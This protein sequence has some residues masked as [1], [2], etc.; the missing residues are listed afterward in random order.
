MWL[1]SWIRDLNTNQLTGTIPS[2]LGMLQLQVLYESILLICQHEL[3][4]DC[5]R[6]HSNLQNNQLLS[7]LPAFLLTLPSDASVYLQ[8]NYFVRVPGHF[9][10]V[11]ST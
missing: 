1:V 3:F 5:T 9:S 7:P 10:N 8:N 6:L 2:E 4:A 11:A